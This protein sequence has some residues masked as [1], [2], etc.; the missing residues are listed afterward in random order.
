MTQNSFL[1]PP[2]QHFWTRSRGLQHAACRCWRCADLLH[3]PVCCWS[4]ARSR[5]GCSSKLAGGFCCCCGFA[6]ADICWI[7]LFSVVFVYFMPL[8]PTFPPALDILACEKECKNFFF[9]LA[10][11]LL[12]FQMKTCSQVHVVVLSCNSLVIL[13]TASVV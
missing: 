4:P 1:V 7:C 8:N 11:Q 3:L 12:I 10:M 2:R 13:C 5:P 9:Y 6:F